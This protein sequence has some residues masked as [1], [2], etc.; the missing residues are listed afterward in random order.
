MDGCSFTFACEKRLVRL[1]TFDLRLVL[2]SLLTLTQI[3]PCSVLCNTTPSTYRGRP[4]ASSTTPAHC[5]RDY[6]A[7][8]FFFRPCIRTVISRIHPPLC[9][10]G[11]N[12]S[13]NHVD[14]G[15][16]LK[17]R[18]FHFIRPHFLPGARSRET[19][20]HGCDQA[21][22]RETARCLYSGERAGKET[23]AELHSPCRRARARNRGTLCCER[24]SAAAAYTTAPH[25]HNRVAP[26]TDLRADACQ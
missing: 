11:K 2:S 15:L 26:H 17:A 25:A 24:T 9:D 19:S 18:L 5:T 3:Q 7:G 8:E 16:C 1:H 20:L 13:R 6:T 21:G 12:H 22:G 23:R 10:L 14:P 4:I